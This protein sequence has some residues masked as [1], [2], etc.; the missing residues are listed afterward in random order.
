MG[1]LYLLCHAIINAPASQKGRQ[2][3]INTFLTSRLVHPYHLDQSISSF[4]CSW[5]MISFLLYFA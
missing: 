1:N 2:T 3:R 5:R 4:N